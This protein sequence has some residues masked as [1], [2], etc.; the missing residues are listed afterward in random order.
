[1]TCIHRSIMPIDREQAP[2]ELLVYYCQLEIATPTGL[3]TPLNCQ[4]CNFNS[5]REPWT[6]TPATADQLAYLKAMRDAGLD[7]N[8]CTAC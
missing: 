5:E 4:A 6:P 7:R 3:T 2:A 1:M 8:G